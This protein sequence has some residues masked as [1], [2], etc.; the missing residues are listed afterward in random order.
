MR[1]RYPR[2]TTHDVATIK[3]TS[4]TGGGGKINAY[5]VLAKR[6]ENGHRFL[7]VTLQD[8]PI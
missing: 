8:L 2:Q 1:V 4:T 6:N 5:V 3:D 7:V